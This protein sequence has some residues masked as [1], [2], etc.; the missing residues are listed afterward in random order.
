[1]GMVVAI[2]ALTFVSSLA[3]EKF[4]IREMLILASLLAIGSYFG[5]IVMLKLQV[6]AWPS[7][8]AG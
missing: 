2:Y 8:I 5:F 3:S 7:F 6:Q 4:R 1:M